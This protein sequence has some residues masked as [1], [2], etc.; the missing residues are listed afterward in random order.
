MFDTINDLANQ[1]LIWID[2]HRGVI[3]ISLLAAAAFLA[4]LAFASYIW[5]KRKVKLQ[6]YHPACSDFDFGPD[7]IGFTV[8]NKHREASRQP[9]MG[10]HAVHA[11]LTGRR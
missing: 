6:G 4:L 5:E 1:V 11:F 10:V 2:E 7:N 9:M 3:V 8:I